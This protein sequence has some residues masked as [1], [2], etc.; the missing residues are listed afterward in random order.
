MEGYSLLTLPLP[1]L[2]AGWRVVWRGRAVVATYYLISI[3]YLIYLTLLSAVSSVCALM[4][5]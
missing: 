4:V 3:P 5:P 1:S 2:T